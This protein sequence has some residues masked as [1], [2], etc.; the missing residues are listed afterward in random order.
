MREKEIAGCLDFVLG[1]WGDV[2]EV[3]PA[4]RMAGNYREEYMDFT[5]SAFYCCFCGG[6]ASDYRFTVPSLSDLAADGKSLLR[7][8]AVR[9]MMG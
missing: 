8:F 1:S 9:S 7:C 5:R 3:A 4:T 2:R 6:S